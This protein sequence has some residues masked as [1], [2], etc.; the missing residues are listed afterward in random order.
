VHRDGDLFGRNVAYAARVAA[1]A[2]GQEVLVSDTVLDVLAVD[3][4][5]V[6][7][8][9]EAELKGVPGTH[10]LHVLDWRA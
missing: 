7:D 10:W 5:R 6:L 9:R 3:S 4:V 8:S 1:Q 2:D